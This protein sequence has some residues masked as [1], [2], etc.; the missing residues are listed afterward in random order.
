MSDAKELL[1]ELAKDLESL[2]IRLDLFD[3][4]MLEVIDAEI[5]H[6]TS[7]QDE[8]IPYMQQMEKGL[9]LAMAGESNSRTKMIE[10]FSAA[11]HPIAESRREYTS[12]IGS[13][14]SSVVLLGKQSGE[15]MDACQ[16]LSLSIRGKFDSPKPAEFIFQARVE[17]ENLLLMLSAKPQFSQQDY[18]HPILRLSDELR[19]DAA[20]RENWNRPRIAEEYYRKLTPVEKQKIRDKEGF[21]K[22]MV[23]IL[24]NH[25]D[26]LLYP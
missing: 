16:N 8:R 7:H 15:K 18:F 25:K 14:L 26:E 13:R 3:Q 5:E 24:R 21:K 23:D 20:Q 2:T 17:V 11:I 1:Q 4:Q 22:Q 19:R 12:Q 6:N 9:V 10:R